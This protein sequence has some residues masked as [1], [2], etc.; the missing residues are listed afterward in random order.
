ML[1][2]SPA[3][4]KFACCLPGAGLLHRYYA[5]KLSSLRAAVEEEDAEVGLGPDRGVQGAECVSVC[6]EG[7]ASCTCMEKEEGV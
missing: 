3:S 5:S 7:C 1:H 4:T 2:L 6:G